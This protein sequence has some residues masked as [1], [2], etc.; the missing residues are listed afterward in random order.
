MI[1]VKP[2]GKTPDYTGQAEFVKD[3]VT[4]LVTKKNNP[5]E[6][7]TAVS[8]LTNDANLRK[9]LIDSAYQ[10]SEKFAVPNYVKAIEEVYKEV[11]GQNS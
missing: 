4:A 1:E 5:V 9:R 6:I 11:L 10:Y 7:C 2:K 8:N 3:G